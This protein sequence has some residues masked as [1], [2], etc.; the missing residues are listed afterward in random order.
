VRALSVN[1]V[2]AGPPTAWLAD[3][4]RRSW[5]TLVVS[6]HPVLRF[7][8]VANNTDGAR[9]QAGEDPEAVLE[10]ASTTISS[11]SAAAVAAWTGQLG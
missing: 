3:G 11:V 2:A 10:A 5:F 1:G 6:T 4:G 9:R 8:T 7:P